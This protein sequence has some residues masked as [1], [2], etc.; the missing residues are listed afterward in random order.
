MW[1]NPTLV[2]ETKSTPQDEPVQATQRDLIQTSLPQSCSQRAKLQSPHMQT[3][4]F[5]SW[6]C[7]ENLPAE[8][9]LQFKELHKMIYS[10]HCTSY[11]TPDCG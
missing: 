1:P 3:F 8:G 7:L 11:L 4:G 9:F 5:E 2:W 10:A 6:V